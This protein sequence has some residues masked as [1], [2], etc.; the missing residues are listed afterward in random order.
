MHWAGG[1]A[2]FML[3]LSTVS[4]IIRAVK[5][6]LRDSYGFKT[7]KQLDA[8]CMTGCLKLMPEKKALS[9]LQSKT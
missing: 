2:K 1:R 5:L 8:I 9:A 7:I 6:Q 3:P 4:N